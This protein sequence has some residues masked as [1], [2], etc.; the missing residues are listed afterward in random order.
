MPDLSF[1]KDLKP[2]FREKDRGSM[3]A[4]FD[5]WSVDDARDN[6]SAI[7]EALRAGTMPCDG[8]WAPDDADLLASWIAA[9]V[10]D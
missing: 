10:A 1:A 3:L 4:Q 9:G 8:Q 7:L 5:L 6:A 2:L